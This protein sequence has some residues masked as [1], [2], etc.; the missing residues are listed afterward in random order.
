LCTKLSL[1]TVN[2]TDVNVIS[3]ASLEQLAFTIPHPPSLQKLCAKRQQV[4][5]FVTVENVKADVFVL[6]YRFRALA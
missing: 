6:S 2:V 1:T 4:V 5:H 3:A